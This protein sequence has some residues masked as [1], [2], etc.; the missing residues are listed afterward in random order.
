MEAELKIV[1]QLKGD[2]A[3]VGVQGTNTDPVV[4]TLTATSLNDVLAAI[5]G[6]L[7]RARE[8]WATSPRNPKYEGPPPPPAPARTTERG[9]ATPQRTANQQRFF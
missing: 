5:P 1:I 4:E 8:K 7:D 3:L 2:R 6:I 9:L